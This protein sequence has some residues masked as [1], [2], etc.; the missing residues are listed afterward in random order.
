ML[1]TTF[2]RFKKPNKTPNQN[3]IAIPLAKTELKT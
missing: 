3:W 1:N 2:G